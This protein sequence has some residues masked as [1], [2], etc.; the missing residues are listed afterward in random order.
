MPKSKAPRKR[1]KPSVST[2]SSMAEQEHL[3]ESLNEP[4]NHSIGLINSTSNVVRLA[5]RP[6][7]LK[8]Y[9]QPQDVLELARILTADLKSYHQ[10]LNAVHDR[11]KS[12]TGP[13]KNPADNMEMIELSEAYLELTSSFTTVVLPNAEQLQSL[14]DAAIEVGK[15]SE[16]SRHD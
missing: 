3:W 13:A 11:H 7:L 1:Y 8:H 4:Y 14:I 12:K 9:A 16:E 10:Q 15:S 2:A 5:A 6:E